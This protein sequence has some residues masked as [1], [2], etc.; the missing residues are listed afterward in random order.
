MYKLFKHQVQALEIAKKHN[1]A[2]FHDCGCGKTATALNI[3]N[4]HGGKALV[5]CP[6]SIIEAAWI[7]GCKKFTPELSIVS[8]CDTPAKRLATLKEQHDIYVVSFDTF[9]IMF[10]QLQSMQFNTLIVDESSKMKCNKTKTARALL[11][12][13]GIPSGSKAARYD[14]RWI[15]PNRYVLSGTPAPNDESEYWS[16]IKFITGRGDNIFSD[17]FYAFRSKYFQ[18][19][20]MP[21]FS[22]WSFRKN[23]K[24]DFMTNLAKVSHT[25]KKEDAVDLPSQTH[26]IRQIQMSAAEIM[27]YTA[28][29]D[30]LVVRFGNEAVLATTALVEV[31]KLRQITSGFVYGNE[32]VHQIGK[33]KLIELQELLAEIG[34]KQVII[35]AN[36]Q[37]EIKTIVDTLGKVGAIWGG[38]NDRQEVIT[39]FQHGKLQYLVC[40]PSSA[41]HGLTFTNCS[42]AIYYSLNYSYEL[43]KQSQDRIHRIGQTKPCTYY[44]LVAKGTIDEVI[45]KAVNKKAD[46][47]NEILTYIKGVQNAKKAS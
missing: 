20:R 3:I 42:Y 37:E 38:A 46:L 19:F 1:L 17:N 10:K 9:R 14:V 40:N 16:Q 8:L 29:K 36:F 30:D 35:W 7:E 25:V 47:S 34:N 44:Y 33:S 21:T 43:Q 15:V 13:A 5:V 31:M 18:E 2:M 27:A 28:M 6:L 23:L 22:K 24:D 39:D 45:Y 26:E 32:G 4:H 41:A 11:A 12:L